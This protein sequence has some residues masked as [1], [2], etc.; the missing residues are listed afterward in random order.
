[1]SS[2]YNTNKSSVVVAPTADDNTNERGV[3]QIRMISMTPLL[4]VE[5]TARLVRKVSQKKKAG[6]KRISQTTPSQQRKEKR[7]NTAAT[8]SSKSKRLLA[9]EKRTNSPL[10]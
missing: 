9:E 2:Y 6:K 7:T 5:A 4:L 10:H 3:Y 8:T 1:M